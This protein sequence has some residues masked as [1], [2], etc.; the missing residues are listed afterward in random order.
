MIRNKRIVSI[1]KVLS[2]ILLIALMSLY[3]IREKENKDYLYQNQQ[4]LEK[5]SFLTE[6]K[7]DLLSDNK[8][9]NHID[10]A[11]EAEPIF[12]YSS[13][14]NETIE[15]IAGVSWKENAP[16]KLEDLAYITVTYWGFDD[17]EHI[18]EMIVHKKLAHEVTDI[19]KEL[20]EGK[21]PIEKIRLIDEYDAKDELSMADNNTSAFC[22]REVTGQKG[23]FSNHS[24]GIA[25]DINPVQ[26]PYIKGEIVLPKEGNTYLDRS[27]VRKGMIIKGDVCYNAFK[28]RGWTWGGE[29]KSLKDYQHFEKKIELD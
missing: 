18:G 21:F 14:S 8:A 29:W 10:K 20:Y 24:Y 17:K 25:I 6:N 28:S 3:M 23:V 16:V 22:S 27:H 15:K 13:L 2:L 26:N 12:K 4:I 19:F 1:F 9:E 5:E 7:L 11:A